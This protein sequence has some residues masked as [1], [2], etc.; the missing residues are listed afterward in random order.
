MT[1]AKVINIVVN[2]SSKMEMQIVKMRKL[3]ADLHLA[4]LHPRTFDLLEF[5]EIPAAEIL[6]GLSTP[7]KATGT[8]ISSS[9]LPAGRGLDARTR[10]TDG[11]PSAT[12]PPEV[13]TW[14]L[15]APPLDL[16]LPFEPEP[17]NPPPP[18]S[19][20]AKVISTLPSNPPSKI[21]SL[22]ST[23]DLDPSEPP[24]NHSPF[25]SD[26]Y[27]SSYSTKLEES[28]VYAGER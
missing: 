25:S 17:S 5:L 24:S 11:Q 1:R 26:P 2:Y 23:T 20:P 15:E 14:I 10:P 6:H 19:A 16:P 7:T 12:S 13:V 18:P 27:S 3:M 22:C 28:F 9:S 21:W 8:M 4:A